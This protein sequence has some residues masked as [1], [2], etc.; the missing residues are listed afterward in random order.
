M[1]GRWALILSPHDPTEGISTST[2][3]HMPDSV[4]IHFGLQGCA[5]LQESIIPH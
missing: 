1:S 2:A 4:C 5:A 3:G